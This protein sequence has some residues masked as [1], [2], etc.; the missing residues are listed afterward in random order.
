MP[1]SDLCAVCGT[2]TQEGDRH[3]V[4]NPEGDSV[5]VCDSCY[6]TSAVSVCDV[7]GNAYINTDPE[8]AH[9]SYYICPSCVAAG[10]AVC[11]GCGALSDELDE[12]GNCPV[13]QAPEEVEDDRDEPHIQ[14]HYWLPAHLIFHKCAEDALVS[15]PYLGFELEVDSPRGERPDINHA[16][17][18]VSE[19]ETCFCKHDGSLIH[20]FELV[21]HPMTLAWH[22]CVG[23]ARKLRHLDAAG[24]L[25]WDRDTCGMHV[26]V[27]R[28]FLTQKRWYRLDDWV[29]EQKKFIVAMAGR[30]SIEFAKFHDDLVDTTVQ[31]LH[32]GGYRYAALNFQNDNTIEFRVFRGTLNPVRFLSNLE[33]VDALCRFV[34]FERNLHLDDFYAFVSKQ[35]RR[36]AELQTYI[37]AARERLCQS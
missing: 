30:H 16:A 1:A 10:Y 11:H 8:D 28:E 23:W 19:D 29:S 27:S 24:L 36:Y 26:H 25:S 5:W 17:G 31:Q 7:C 13:C 18:L 15:D 32:E 9:R 34:K 37:K 6:Q 14:D 12:N 22:K 33:L 35:P 20:G 21:S 4:M 3:L 2:A